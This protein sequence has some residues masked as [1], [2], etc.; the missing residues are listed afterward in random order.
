MTA[1][2]VTAEVA[3]ELGERLAAQAA[4]AGLEIDMARVT[5]GALGEMRR[6]SLDCPDLADC[7]GGPE[8]PY[9]GMEGTEGDRLAEDIMG[10]TITQVASH[11]TW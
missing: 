9:S 2:Q 1:A 7:P 3:E 11:H 10:D 5:S 4:A 8:D 6:A